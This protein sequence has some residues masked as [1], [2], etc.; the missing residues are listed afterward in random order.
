[1][2]TP[3]EFVFTFGDFYVCANFGE[4]SSR[5]ASVRVHADGH[6][7]RDKMVIIFPCCML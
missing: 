2:F 4:N 6:T 1:M 5:N 3:Y 7:N